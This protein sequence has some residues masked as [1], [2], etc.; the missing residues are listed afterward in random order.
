MTTEESKDNEI[1]DLSSQMIPPELE[2]LAIAESLPPRVVET[3]EQ[4]SDR[5]KTITE[6]MDDATDL[7]D[8]QFAAS[9][10]FPKSYNR[11]QAMVARIAPEAYLSLLQLMVTDTIMTAKPE[12]PINVND[13]VFDAYYILSTGL[14]GM[15]R[16]DYA[17]LLGAAREAKRDEN[18]LKGL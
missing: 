16:I 13:A 9:N 6:S 18:L 5:P 1:N 10:L 14:E 11:R 3:P 17:E 15:G 8:L 12:E 7:T 2:Y 4:A